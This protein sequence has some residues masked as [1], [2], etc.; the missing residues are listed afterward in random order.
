[1]IKLHF[2]VVEKL[3]LPTETV[4]GTVAE[5]ISFLGGGVEGMDEKNG[6]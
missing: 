4:Y 1:M 3:A 5:I 2:A 6:V